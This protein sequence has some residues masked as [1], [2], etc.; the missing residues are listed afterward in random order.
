MHKE[1]FALMSNQ[2]KILEIKIL[3]IRL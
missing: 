1:E 2:I 3:E